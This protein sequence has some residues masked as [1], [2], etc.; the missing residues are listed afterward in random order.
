MASNNVLAAGRHPTGQCRRALKMPAPLHL[1][2][3]MQEG[4]PK[5]QD[6]VVASMDL[7]VVLALLFDVTWEG[8]DNRIDPVL[9]VRCPERFA[10]PCL[11]PGP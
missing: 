2:P 4:G 11:V 9:K 6:F 3:V 8:Q 1:E 5:C 10:C 7:Q